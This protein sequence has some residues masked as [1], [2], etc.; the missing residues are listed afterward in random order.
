VLQESS[1][2]LLLLHCLLDALLCS[3]WKNISLHLEQTSTTRH[4][5]LRK[6]ITRI[7]SPKLTTPTAIKPSLNRRVVLQHSTKMCPPPGLEFVLVKIY[8]RNFRILWTHSLWFPSFGAKST[9]WW[10]QGLRTRTS[11]GVLE[12]CLQKIFE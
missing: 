4:L 5:K 2:P 8:Y 3:Q 7:H 11:L 9:A 10:E 1:H 12:R 6:S